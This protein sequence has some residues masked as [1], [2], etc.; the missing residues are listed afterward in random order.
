[1]VAQKFKWQMTIEAGLITQWHSWRSTVEGDVACVLCLFRMLMGVGS[2]RFSL[3][4]GTLYHSLEGQG[5]SLRWRTWDGPANILCPPFRMDCSSV[6][7]G[8]VCTSV[9]IIF[10]E[11]LTIRVDLDF[12]WIVKLP[13]PAC[14]PYPIRLFLCYTLS[15]DSSYFQQHLLIFYIK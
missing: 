14:I 1:M 10:I 11:V 9:L 13:Y 2:N 6:V 8:G 5:W 12:D 3:Q 7:W 15:S 4:L